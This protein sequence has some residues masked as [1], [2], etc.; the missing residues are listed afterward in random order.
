MAQGW[1]RWTRSK[2]P[3]CWFLVFEAADAANCWLGVG[4][5]TKAAS[6][7]CLLFSLGAALPFICR[8]CSSRNIFHQNVLSLTSL[9]TKSICIYD[10][11]KGMEC[12]YLNEEVGW[13]S[14]QVLPKCD[15]FIT[16]D[17]FVFFFF[18]LILQK[19]NSLY[20]PSCFYF[21]FYKGKLVHL[22]RMK[23]KDKLHTLFMEHWW[24]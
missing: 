14:L 21:Y 2:A 9:V 19:K 12:L 16:L 10:C 7:S 17:L 13:I 1:A 22:F 8:S 24:S 20:V 5:V 4:R 18:K 23:C 15:N 3:L 6:Y 11:C